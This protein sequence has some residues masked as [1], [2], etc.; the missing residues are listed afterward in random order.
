MINGLTIRG[1]FR[2]YSGHDRT[3]RSFVRELDA[4]GVAIE[5]VDNPAWAPHKLPPELR[6]PWFE[7]FNR[8]VNARAALQFCMPHQTQAMPSRFTINFTMFEASR[9]PADWIAHNL[10][11]GQVFVPTA[12]SKSAWV[13]SGMPEDRIALCPLGVDSTLFRPKLTPAD[14]VDNRGRPI[15]QYAVRV[16]NVSDIVPRK[17]LLSLLRVWIEATTATDDAILVVKLTHDAASHLKLLRDLNLLER[18]LGKSRDQA[19]AILFLDQPL[20]DSD[21][22]QLYAAMTHYWSMSCGEGWD[23]PMTEAGATG[24]HLIAP[25]NSAYTSY[26]SDDIA[27]LLPC[28]IVDAKQPGDQRSPPYFE[29]AQWWPPSEDAART[30]I[31]RLLANPFPPLRSARQVLADKFSWKTATNRLVAALR[32]THAERGYEFMVP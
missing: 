15:S 8:P 7:Q 4:L 16:L 29:N 14:L 11:Q 24:L 20:P 10:R 17:N 12:S 30:V 13:K 2:G 22:P 23:Q 27:T 5:L 25:R 26:L 9:V 3:V 18:A 32:A 6:D 31:S 28:H 19:A 21:M 1:S